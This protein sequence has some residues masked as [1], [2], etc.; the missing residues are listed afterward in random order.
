MREPAGA[1]TRKN[2][3][4]KITADFCPPF[5]VDIAGHSPLM[6]LFRNQAGTAGGPEANAQ[7]RRVV[8]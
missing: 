4:Q 3:A 2:G 7:G 1:F 6:V 5:L 8:L